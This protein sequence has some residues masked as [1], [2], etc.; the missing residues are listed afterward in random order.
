MQ[1]NGRTQQRHLHQTHDHGHVSVSIKTLCGLIV[2]TLYTSVSPAAHLF[3][4]VS[5]F[6]ALLDICVRQ[7]HFALTIQRLQHG[8]M[9]ENHHVLIYCATY[10]LWTPPDT[11]SVDEDDV[12]TLL[13]R[14]QN[15]LEAHAFVS[16]FVNWSCVKFSKVNPLTSL[17]SQNFLIR[18]DF[19]V[20]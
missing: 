12:L 17:S 13:T 19:R 18:L 8:K 9:Y 10:K 3:L 7:W 1:H 4:C 6:T 5:T 2:L 14:T 15:K 11:Q 20:D 16:F